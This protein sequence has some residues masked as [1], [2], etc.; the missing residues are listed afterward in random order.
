MMFAD[1]LI[2][3]GENRQ[4]DEANLESWRYALERR[5]IKVSRCKTEYVCANE[6][7]GQWH[8]AV[9][10][11]RGGQSGRTEVFGVNCAN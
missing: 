9:A 2:I 5:E 4:Q 11:S 6:K 3:C 10:R 8:S 1:D 7:R